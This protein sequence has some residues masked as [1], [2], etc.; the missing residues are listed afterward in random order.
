VRLY[1]KTHIQRI[2]ADTHGDKRE[3]ASRLGI[4]LASV[5][6]KLSE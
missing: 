4:G 1:E 3:A 6:R 2:L 5:Y